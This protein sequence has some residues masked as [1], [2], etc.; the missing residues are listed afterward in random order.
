MSLDQFLYLDKPKDINYI[1]SYLDSN[2]GQIY[3]KQWAK[4]RGEMVK[5]KLQVLDLVK[6][7]YGREEY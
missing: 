7:V 3:K 4:G 5:D 1:A 2:I 6:E